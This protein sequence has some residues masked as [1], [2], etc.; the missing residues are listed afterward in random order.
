MKHL[1]YGGVHPADKK[2]LSSGVALQRLEKPKQVIIPMSQHIGVPCTPMVKVG[3]LVKKGQKI[4]DGK[5]LCVP[6]HASV[7]GKV[8]AVEPRRHP[9]GSQVL[10]VVIEND[11]QG[12][13]DES[14]TAYAD[15]TS[16]SED[17]I[18]EIIR[19][20]GIVGMGGA[21]FATS[22]KA[23]VEAEIDTLIA[24]ACECEP[25]ITADDML[26]RTNP[27]QVIAGMKIIAQ[28]VN[29]KKMVLAIEENKKEAIKVLKGLL[30]KEDNIE[31]RVLPTRY[32]QGAERQLVQAITGREIVPGQLPPSVGC[33]VFNV[34]TYEATY[35]AVCLGKPITGRIVTVT[36]E[37]VKNPGN[38]MVPMGMPVAELIEAAGGLTEDVWKVING[39]PMMGLAQ[40]DLDTCV[41]K[42]TNAVLCLSN[43]QN[44]EAGDQICIRCGKC[45]GV[46]PTR[47]QPLYMYAYAKKNDLEGLKRFR[48]LDCIE[49]GSCAYE[50]P[51]KLPLVEQ[52]R[53]GKKLVR[54]AMK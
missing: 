33:V 11:F 35:R 31:L 54:E 9:N 22:I 41:I 42:G 34:A 18:I 16:L 1:F 40:P 53:I 39:G 13:L 21:T 26:L 48:V 10:S 7:S 25:Y 2:E 36:G 47:L 28:V 46:C 49:C 32:P 14:M 12:T 15:Y 27:E 5:G 30:T 8:V 19:E 45:L 52:F 6:V 44:G 37:A 50:C 23:A 3:D 20:A 17:E 51:G 38:F 43:A 24:N 29:P 4:G